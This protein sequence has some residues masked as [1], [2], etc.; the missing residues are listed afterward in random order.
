[1]LY[2]QNELSDHSISSSQ[3][4]TNYWEGEGCGLTSFKDNYVFAMYRYLE[5]YS[6]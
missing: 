5:Q 4:L 6:P 3:T 1:M 2:D